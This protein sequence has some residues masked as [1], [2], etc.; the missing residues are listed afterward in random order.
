MILPICDF[1]YKS[2]QISRIVHMSLEEID[3]EES[4]SSLSEPSFSDDDLDRMHLESGSS[5]EEMS[6]DEAGS[7]I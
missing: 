2:S 5:D 4:A 3:I 7:N 6:D 1:T